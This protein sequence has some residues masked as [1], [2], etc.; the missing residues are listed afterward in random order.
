[1][2]PTQKEWIDNAS[3]EALLRRWRFAP[4]GDPMLQ[5]DTGDYYSKVMSQR[6]AEV[7]DEEHTA[8]SK[9]IGWDR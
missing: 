3:Y 7:G 8:A 5:G 1:M 2:T 6:R 4:V 9:R